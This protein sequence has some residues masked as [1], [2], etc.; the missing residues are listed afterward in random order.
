M[1]IYTINNSISDPSRHLT[2]DQ[3]KALLEGDVLD[4][5]LKRYAAGVMF[6]EASLD[7]IVRFLKR[8]QIPFEKARRLYRIWKNQNTGACDAK[9]EWLFQ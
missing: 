9:Y 3:L 1:L 2:E 8:W 6:Q 7:E 5:P 4:T